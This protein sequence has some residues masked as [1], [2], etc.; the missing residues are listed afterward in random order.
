MAMALQPV[1]LIA[2]VV[3]TPFL[4]ACMLFCVLLAV[5]LCL[6]GA[7]NGPGWARPAG[8]VCAGL[9]LLPAVLN[10]ALLL[11]GGGPANTGVEL[12]ESRIATMNYALGEVLGDHLAKKVDAG[13]QVLILTNAQSSKSEL[14]DVTAGLKKGFGDKLSVAATETVDDD[15]DITDRSG[16][17][18]EMIRLIGQSA[19]CGLVIT[20]LDV[21]L[22][23]YQAFRKGD[24]QKP[25]FA[26][27]NCDVPHL[28]GLIEQEAVVAVVASSTHTVVLNADAPPIKDSR[29]LFNKYFVLIDAGTM[30]NVKAEHPSIFAEE[31]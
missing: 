23:V 18:A 1:L 31:E 26:L 3:L 13:T 28:E 20:D 24:V 22:S 30:A 27:F 29:E 25:T 12:P 4:V 14:D 15:P 21:P 5:Q 17:E 6:I 19:D 2:L 8:G 11:F 10:A 9:A 7:G 16:A